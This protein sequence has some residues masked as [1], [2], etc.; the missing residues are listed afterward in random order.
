MREHRRAVLK[1]T[2]RA[3]PLAARLV[4]VRAVSNSAPAQGLT[5][6]ALG[7]LATGDA[8][9][10]AEVILDPR[11]LTSL[12]TRRGR[13]TTRSSVP[14]RGIDRGAQTAGPPPTITTS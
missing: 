5:P 12:A 9:G 14:R 6:G 4:T 3:E 1:E 11:A 13:S 7:Q 10:E 2:C 8:I